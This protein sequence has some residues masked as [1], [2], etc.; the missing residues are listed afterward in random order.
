M[1]GNETYESVSSSSTEITFN[2][3]EGSIS[4]VV[5]RT[6]IY[7]QEN[8]LSVTVGTAGK[9]D[10]F[11]NGKPV[12]GCQEIKATQTANAQCKWKPSLLG[13]ATVMAVLTPTNRTLPS[14]N[15]LE[16]GATVVRR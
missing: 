7:Q 12:P 8:L 9:V 3:D 5:P 15:S 11:Q 6:I 10:F 14:V 4:L 13:S 16:Y 1:A 2:V